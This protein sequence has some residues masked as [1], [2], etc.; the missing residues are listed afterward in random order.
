MYINLFSNK[1]I[2]KKQFTSIVLYKTLQ[3]LKV[4]DVIDDDVNNTAKQHYKPRLH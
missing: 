1:L 4:S 2:E 3:I